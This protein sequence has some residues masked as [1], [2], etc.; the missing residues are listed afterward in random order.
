MMSEDLLIW[1]EQLS[2]IT[3]RQPT[4]F[5]RVKA[6]VAYA[7]T[8]ERMLEEKSGGGQWDPGARPLPNP[9][10]D[11]ETLEGRLREDDSPVIR[12]YSWS[13]VDTFLFLGIAAFCF[14]AWLKTR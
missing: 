7:R 14:L 6:I 11:N 13:K 1:A 3:K 5:D 12:A 10:T 2:P 4:D 8:L 9:T